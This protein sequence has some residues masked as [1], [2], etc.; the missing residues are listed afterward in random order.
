MKYCVGANLEIT[1]TIS[2]SALTECD[3]KMFPN[4]LC[5]VIKTSC[6]LFVSTTT[7]ARL[8]L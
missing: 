1:N 2:I 3:S 6:I 5:K 7:K 8:R 4:I